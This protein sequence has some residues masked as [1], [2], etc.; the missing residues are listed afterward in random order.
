[1]RTPASCSTPPI[2]A[3]L[4]AFSVTAS[5]ANFSSTARATSPLSDSTGLC[6]LLPVL[7]SSHVSRTHATKLAALRWESRDEGTV[8]SL[9][10]DEVPASEVDPEEA[11][12]AML[13]SRIGLTRLGGER[14]P[15][16]LPTG[17]HV[18]L[19]TQVRKKPRV[20]RRRR[21]GAM[22][23]A[24]RFVA[25]PRFTCGKTQPLHV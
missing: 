11:P 7:R 23:R 1:M 13:A 25:R 16:T 10:L 20:G 21:F 18:Q 12:V 2:G 24:V 17:G 19:E 6:T 9:L 8:R 15:S 5:T 22:S 14:S 3:G 4:R